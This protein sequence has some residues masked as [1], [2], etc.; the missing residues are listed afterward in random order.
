MLWLVLLKVLYEIKKTSS[1]RIFCFFNPEMKAETEVFRFFWTT[2]FKIIKAVKEIM[3][4]KRKFN[5][6]SMIQKIAHQLA[7]AKLFGIDA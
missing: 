6:N 1:A 7:F 4:N 2:P 3:Q 5:T